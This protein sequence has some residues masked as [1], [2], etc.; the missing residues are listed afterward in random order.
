M[1]AFELRWVR[2]AITAAQRADALLALTPPELTRYQA[3]GDAADAFLAGRALLRSL[4]SELTGMPP[5]AIRISANCPD[6]GG[7][8]GRPLV[9]DCALHLSLSRCP[10][11]IVAVASWDGPIGV[12]VEQHPASRS[13]IE[14]IETLTGTADLRQWTRLEAVLK[15]DGRGLRVD[16]AAVSI[17]ETASAVEG[18]IAGSDRRYLLTEPAID[19]RLFV[20]VAS[21]L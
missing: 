19:D 6:C 3:A 5:A 18:T 12:D 7:A 14:A 2:P 10:S 17:L 13:A 11:A 1:D 9:E 16:P 20:C 8:H 21:C 15:A 4:V